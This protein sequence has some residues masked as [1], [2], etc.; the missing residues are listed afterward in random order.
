M[1]AQSLRSSGES[2][3]QQTK[4]FSDYFRCESSSNCVDSD[5]DD[6][7]N[8]SFTS[9]DENDTGDSQSF[10]QKTK[11]LSIDNS[12]KE[13]SSNSSKNNTTGAQKSK[14][15]RCRPRS[16]NS[17]QRIRRN[18]RVK[19]NDR[20]RNRMHGLNKA[21]ERLRKILPTYSEDTKLTKIETLR[22][23][24]NYIWALSE[25]LRLCDDSKEAS[26]VND[27]IPTIP[28]E[29]SGN[30]VKFS[31]APITA[32]KSVTDSSFSKTSADT[33]WSSN[34]SHSY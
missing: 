34:S 29:N 25:T 32:N 10:W 20:E 2:Y 9:T 17:V 24:H 7:N 1:S 15:R 26:D 21:L 30:S 11:L 5:F 14:T 19:A 12:S 31:F 13:N 33:F 3:K 22:F 6:H 27:T 4:D 18:R 28:V 16:P 8:L 23:A